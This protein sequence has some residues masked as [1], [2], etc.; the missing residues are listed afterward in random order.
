MENICNYLKK[1]VVENTKSLQ[2]NNITNEN[3]WI[4][5]LKKTTN[6]N[7]PDFSINGICT[8]CKIVH[9]YDADTFRVAFFINKNDEHPIKMKV[10][11]SGCNSAEMYPLKSHPNRQEEMRKAKVARNR[12]VQLITET[13]FD[14]FNVDYFSNEDIKKLLDENTKL[15]YIEFGKFDKYGRVLGTL[16]LDDGEANKKKS[17]NQML[18]D[19]NHAVYYDGGKRDKNELTVV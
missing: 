5:K 12:L 16:Y 7:I 10:R 1:D 11:A 4:E 14:I 8:L 19:E 2:F 3:D 18:I 13:E 9:V 6:D 15:L 17:I